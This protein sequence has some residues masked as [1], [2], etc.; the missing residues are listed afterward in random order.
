MYQIGNCG[1][2]LWKKNVLK[3]L[4]I[5]D[6]TEKAWNKIYSLGYDV[7]E[8]LD[9]LLFSLQVGADT[10]NADEAVNTIADA[11]AKVSKQRSALGA[12]QNRL[13]HTINN[14][15]NV[16][17][18]T[19]SA[20]AAIRDTDIA[21]EMVKYERTLRQEGMEIGIKQGVEIGMQKGMAAGYGKR[22]KIIQDFPKEWFTKPLFC[23]MMFLE[24]DF[25]KTFS[26]IMIV[27]GMEKTWYQLKTLRNMR[28]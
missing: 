26:K 12:V 10:T 24:N 6:E 22:S 20:E 4:A 5:F 14:L 17:E 11:I 18:N 16:V 1:S 13:E 23:Y 8:D 7:D 9:V 3:W 21:E 15:D 19:T 28:G 2:K 27:F 25:W